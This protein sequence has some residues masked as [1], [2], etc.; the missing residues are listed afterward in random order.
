MI[1][2]SRI[3]NT[4]IYLLKRNIKDF[5]F[6]FTFFHISFYKLHFAISFIFEENAK[7]TEMTYK[8]LIALKN[9]N[10]RCILKVYNCFTL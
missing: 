3:S 9:L 7:D 6:Y 10:H 4:R 8:E 2:T 5:T 1:D